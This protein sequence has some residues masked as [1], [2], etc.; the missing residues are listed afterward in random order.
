MS[1]S[2]TARYAG[3]CDGCGCAIR[4]GS[5]V[6]FQRQKL[7]HGSAPGQGCAPSGD[8]HADAEYHRG[9]MDAERFRDDVA[10]YGEETANLMEIERELREGWDY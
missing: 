1:K 3:T 5:L 9:V 7:Y 6:N 8:R 4:A 10:C 2:F